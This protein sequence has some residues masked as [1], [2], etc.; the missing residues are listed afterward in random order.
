MRKQDRRKRDGGAAAQLW[1]LLRALGRSRYRKRLGL[2]ALG[3]FIVVCANT[4]GQIRLNFWNGSFYDTLE[5][6]SFWALGDE[7][8]T[9]LIIVGGLLTLVVAQTWLQE[10]IKVRLRE[11]LTHDLLDD[12]LAPKRAYLLSHAGDV[13]VNPDQRMQDDARQLAELTASLAFGLLQSSLLLITF[14]GVLWGLSSQVVFAF[15]GKSFSIP[16]YMVWCAI[17]YAAM[18]SWLTSESIALHRGEHD[19]R[20]IMNGTVNGVV[21]IGQQIAHGI[22]RLTWVTSGYGWLAIIVPILVASPGYFMGAMSLGGLM[23]VVGAFNQ[24]QQSLRWF[25]DNFPTIATWRAT[26]F[27]VMAFRDAMA[28]LAAAPKPA[29]RIEIVPHPAGRLAFFRLRIAQPEGVTEFETPRVEIGRGERVLIASPPS[30]DK[31]RLLRAIAGLWTEGDGRILLPDPAAM[32]FVPARPYLPLT[33]LRA[34]VTYPND[35]AA[36][37]DAAVTA[38]LERVGLD[39][40]VPRLAEQ[41]RWDK[42]LSSDEQHRLALARLVLHAPQWVIFEDTAAGMSE[43]HCYLIRTLFAEELAGSAVIGCAGSPALAGF[44]TRTLSQRHHG[45]ESRPLPERVRLAPAA[46]VVAA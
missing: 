21:G 9:F 38:A 7:L 17:L 22:A 44:Y 29:R 45:V 35:S 31:S 19:E 15:H 28:K 11:W 32:M 16:G 46:E 26:L 13:G 8:L 23:M 39:H 12:W 42:L 36:F 27:R 5:R 4:Y 2:L 25:V 18:G 33:T 37:A 14:V 30:A 10:T 34:A 6:R 40:L 3:L 1:C 24:V 20:R 43:E 41:E